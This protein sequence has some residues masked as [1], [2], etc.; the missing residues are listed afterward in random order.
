MGGDS[1]VDRPDWFVRALV[2]VHN[3][4]MMI[5]AKRSHLSMS[6]DAVVIDS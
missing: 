1:I 4:N 2:N 3:V 6:P 5:H